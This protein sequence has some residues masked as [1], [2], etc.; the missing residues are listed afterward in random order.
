MSVHTAFG[1]ILKWEEQFIQDF[2]GRALYVA[3][4]EIAHNELDALDAKIKS[5]IFGYCLRNET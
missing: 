4:R 5:E 2:A 3:Y 1:N